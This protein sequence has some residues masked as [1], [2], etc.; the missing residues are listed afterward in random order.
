MVATQ[1][2]RRR[3][4]ATAIV[5]V[6]LFT[7]VPFT[8][9]AQAQNTPSGADISVRL[10]E[11]Q[12]FHGAFFGGARP[13]HFVDN[14]TIGEVS[15]HVPVYN[16]GPAINGVPVYFWSAEAPD[17]TDCVKVN[18]EQGAPTAPA[19]GVAVF[20][21]IN[22]RFLAAGAYNFTIQAFPATRPTAVETEEDCTTSATNPTARPAGPDSNCLGTGVTCRLETDDT[23]NW[24]RA[25]LVKESFLDLR[26]KEVRWCALQTNPMRTE[27]CNESMIVNDKVYNI[28]PPAGA[29]LVD[30]YFEVLVENVADKTHSRVDVA[31]YGTCPATGACN[32]DGFAYELNITV[33]QPGWPTMWANATNHLRER[34]DESGLTHR[35][36]SSDFAINDL[37]GVFNVTVQIDP[38]NL[39]RRHATDASIDIAKRDIEVAYRE[40]KGNFTASTFATTAE[41]AYPYD[42]PFVIAGNITFRNAGPA[43]VPS[44]KDIKIS[45]YLDNLSTTNTKFVRNFLYTP[46]ENFSEMPY[47]LYWDAT[48]SLGADNYLPPGRHTIYAIMDVDNA[49]NE[50]NE[51]NNN[52][53]LD[54]FVRDRTDPR[55]SGNPRIAL[56]EQPDS[57]A[58]AFFRPHEGFNVFATVADD[59]NN[60]RVY[61]NFSLDSNRSVYRLVRMDPDGV[62]ANLYNAQLFDMNFHNFSSI[63]ID[64]TENWTLSIYANDSFGNNAT[65]PTRPFKLKAWPL[66]NATTESI[67]LRPTW[68][69][70]NQSWNLGSDPLWRIRVL[71]NMT[72]Y[73]DKTDHQQFKTS[74]L[75]YNVTVV[76]TGRTFNF[77]GTYWYPETPRLT[78]NEP[79]PAPGCSPFAGPP[80]PGSG[81]PA[82]GVV[83]G[84][85]AQTCDDTLNNTFRAGVLR[86]DMESPGTWNY[87]IRITDIANHTRVING[88]LFLEDFKPEIHNWNL[89]GTTEVT[90]PGNLRVQANVSDDDNEIA[91]AYLNLTRVSPGDGMSMNISLSKRTEEAKGGFTW[92]R[93]NESVDVRRGSPTSI[94]IGGVFNASI[95]VVDGVGNWNHTGIRENLTIKDEEAPQLVTF[96]ATPPVVEIGENVTFYATASDATNVSVRIEIF[97]NPGS[98]ELLVDPIV[99]SQPAG[100]SGW[101][102]TH[103]MN[104]S[105]EAQHSFRITAIDSVNRVST[106]GT[107][108]VTVRDNLGPKYDIVSPSVRLDGDRYG[109]ATPRIEVIVRDV[110]GVVASSIEMEVAGLPV[111]HDLL[112]A[113]GN[114]EGYLVSYTVP[115][116][117]KFDHRDLVEVS[118]KARDNSSEALASE[119]N[120]TFIVDDV[121]PTVRIVS[122][123]PSYRDQPAHVL[124][125]SLASRFTLAAE[126]V[127]GLPTQVPTGGIRYRILGG[128]PGAAE[129]VYSGPFRINDAAGVYTGPRLYQI[130]FWAEDDV[131]NF[132][133]NLNVTT[134]YVDDTPPALFQFFPQGRS[135]NATFVD[136][137]V[138]VNRS[139]VWYR[140]ND[141]AYVPLPLVEREGAWTIQLPEGVKGDRIAYYLQAWDRLDNTETFGN[142]TSPYASFDVSNHEPRLR[143]TAPADGG[144]VSRTFELTWDASDEDG[145]ALVFTL[146]YRAPGRTNF[147]EL[148]KLENTAARRYSVDTTRFADGQYTFRVAAGDGAFVKLA[149]TTVTVINRADAI[150]TVSV[151]G[152]ATPGG[153]MLVTAEVTKAEATLVEARLY[154]GTELV[155]AFAM[156]DG[157]RDGDVTANDGIWSTRV[158]I[159]AA[160]DYRV[161]IFTQYRED[162][163]LKESSLSPTSAAFSAKLTPGYIL[164][165]YG[166]IIALIGL[167]AA[168]G[169]G[170]AVFVV[171]RRR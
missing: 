85:G 63:P 46:K 73:T 23:N 27:P 30:T 93:Y 44:D 150:G 61:A 72:G 101:N 95:H 20:T 129:T 49:L 40:F 103:T 74:N 54:I 167:L 157:G 79:S 28:T 16:V 11:A 151:T 144:R 141:Q 52:F 114:L 3:A 154:Q 34:A 13:T 45:V 70:A 125:V 134:V 78:Q 1:F 105:G 76:S 68:P 153:T 48:S 36:W 106:V 53:S 122:I 15:L 29:T 117:K 69:A 147:V 138:G 135:I 100:A 19:K 102:Y 39:L 98:S 12:F 109:S 116:S 113:P 137:R 2:V 156:N 66:H 97:R 118:L 81:T 67:I 83:P 26:I 37:H 21:G 120:F 145:D 89:T 107:G 132:N 75:A 159:N 60:L 139:V 96:G 8:P 160:G 91:G 128:G 47:E 56:V 9:A 136:D 171:M 127:D 126:D 58:P 14:G 124:N 94:G 59:D 65:G 131:G 119:M 170:V 57:P 10:G 38:R 31:N 169:I 148:A 80:Q 51:S 115:P 123:T 17:R 161:E 4:V 41:T 88:T 7:L 42:G 25:F 111:D 35:A 163:V 104:F 112:P 142:A 22:T 158:P 87:S 86:V 43:P 50:T 168:V 33:T 108:M 162:G 32:P 64:Q 90:P 18:I 84:T 121:A 130:Q 6:F 143:I 99:I 71:G 164:T 82:E 155:D 55:I 5:A 165:E 152:D 62:V 110:E 140:L 24:A 92:Y 146:Y 133:R 77:N 149:E 166:A